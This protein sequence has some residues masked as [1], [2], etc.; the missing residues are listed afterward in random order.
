MCDSYTSPEVALHDHTYTLPT[1]HLINSM[2]LNATSGLSLIAAAAAVVSPSLSKSTG[3]GGGGGGGGLGGKMSSSLSPVKAPRGRPPSSQ[4]RG[5][6]HSVTKLAPSQLTP[7][8]NSTYVPLTDSKTTLKNRTRTTAPSDR[9]RS[10]Q[11]S[12]MHHPLPRIPVT[13]TNNTSSSSSALSASSSARRAVMSSKHSF[14]PSL[15]SMIVSQPQPSSNAAF[16]TLVNVAVAAHPAELPKTQSASLAYTP[17]SFSSSSSSSLPPSASNLIPPHPQI[18]TTASQSSTSSSSNNSSN[19][20]KPYHHHHHHHL[21]HQQQTQQPS[22]A[23]TLEALNILALSLQQ[24]QQQSSGSGSGS[25]S[26]SVN[27]QQLSIQSLLVQTPQEFLGKLPAGFANAVAVTS[28]SSAASV[29]SDAA[30][31][32]SETSKTQSTSSSST[33]AP[34]KTSLAPQSNPSMEDSSS[35]Q[36]ATSVASSHPKDNSVSHVPTSLSNSGGSLTPSDELSNLNLLSSLVAAVASNQPANA[37][38]ATAPSTSVPVCTKTEP[39]TASSTRPVLLSQAAASQGTAMPLQQRSTVKPSGGTSVGKKTD[40]VLKNLVSVD[41]R[42]SS[43]ATAAVAVE[44]PGSS[45][46]SSVSHNTLSASSHC[47]PVALHNSSVGQSVSE[48]GS[49]SSTSL[50]CALSVSPSTPGPVSSSYH[51]PMSQQSSL[52]L[53]TRSLSLPLQPSPPPAPEED[54]L[55]IATRGISE[56]SK[57]LGTDSGTDSSS[58]ENSGVS[59]GSGSKGSSAVGMW[60]ASSLPSLKS[61]RNCTP[62]PSSVTATRPLLSTLLESQTPPPPSSSSLQAHHHHH[63]PPP[64]SS[65]SSSDQHQPPSKAQAK[66]TIEFLR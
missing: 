7:A 20:T 41:R 6:S 56:L 35:S 25:T 61:S 48:P 11:S 55:E 23:P 15:K 37:I 30:L 18:S 8:G 16:E 63:H 13:A 59:V 24:Q 62:S 12:R 60:N 39:T 19:S 53:Y 14:S 42:L 51:Q 58:S 36:H 57:L 34:S 47:S 38:S 66:D 10:I 52:L 50:S 45:L 2:D 3:G 49:S 33:I 1:S 27:P 65:S 21:Q 31:V 26:S 9:T 43:T 4:K 46:S 40:S 64:S 32:S 22:S 28:S 54:H 5:N 44:M 17:S 29:S